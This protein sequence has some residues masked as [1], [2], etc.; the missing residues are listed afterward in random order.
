MDG[1]GALLVAKGGGPP[2]DVVHTEEIGPEILS[3]D[4]VVHHRGRCRPFRKSEAGVYRASPPGCGRNPRGESR[5][6]QGAR[7]ARRRVKERVGGRE[8]VGEGE[9]RRGSILSVSKNE[10]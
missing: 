4:P 2:R 6:L 1:A 7:G 8:K 10:Q 3:S 9:N 5:F